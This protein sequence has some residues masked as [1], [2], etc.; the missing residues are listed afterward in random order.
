MNSCLVPSRSSTRTPD[1]PTIACTIG[2]TEIS[3]ALLDL[4]ASINL[5]PPSAYQQLE[6]GELRPTQLTIQLADRCVKVP[7]GKITD[8]LIRAGDFIYPVDF[9]VLETQHVSN[10]RAQ[11]PVILG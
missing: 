10:P 1:A 11:T 4:S 8:V 5:L 6:L 2:Q 9:I 3:R 7:K